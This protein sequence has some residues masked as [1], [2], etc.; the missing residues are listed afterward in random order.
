MISYYLSE[1]N[2][3]TELLISNNN[4]ARWMA[5]HGGKLS[6]YFRDQIILRTHIVMHHRSHQ[7]EY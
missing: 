7:P 1:E 4:H 6:D 2:F 5:A 3:A